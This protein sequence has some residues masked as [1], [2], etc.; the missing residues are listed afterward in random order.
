MR[1]LSGLIAVMLVAITHM[2]HANEKPHILYINADDLGIMDVGY[3]HSEFNTPNIDRLAKEGMTFTKGYA[4]A[5]NCAPSRACVHSGQYGPRHGV[6]TVNGSARG[7]AKARKLVPIENTLYLP[8]DMLTMARVLKNGGYKTIHIGKYHLGEDPLKQGFDI[9]IGGNK[10]GSPTGGYFAPWSKTQMSGIDDPIEKGT[11]RMDV[12]AEETIKFIAANKDAPMFIHFSP[13]L[14]H[15]PIQAVPEFVDKYKNAKIP[16]A[17]ASMVEKFDQG[18][19]RVLDALAEHGVA[20]NT[21]IA[22]CSDNG[23]IRSISTQ[24]PYRAG[25]GSYYEGGIREPFLM[26][27]P[28][29]IKAGS[30]C[31]VPVIALDF[32]PTFLA[33]SGIKV[34]EGK[35]LDGVSLMPLI[36]G[37]GTIKDRNLYWHFPIYLQAYNGAKDDARDTLFRTRPGSAMLSGKWKLHH[38]FEDDAWEL[39]DLEQDTGERKNL[40]ESMPEKLSEL[41]AAMNAWRAEM[42]A[43]IPSE[44]NPQYDPNS[45]AAKK[46]KK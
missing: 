24:A 15:T 42:K 36:T 5:A 25:K 10:G 18:V 41:Q 27:W 9:N 31:D 45:K 17:Y 1:R 26:K 21:L 13:Y 4:P 19:G 46:K 28:G 14:V 35:I 22:L 16:A 29:K 44:K 7:S 37:E 38:Y 40:A 8:D 32:F 23:G 30:V 20:D 2:L 12:F 11:H 34:P 43:P 33:A 39:Y 6:Y 3:N